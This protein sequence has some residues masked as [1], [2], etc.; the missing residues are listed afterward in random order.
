MNRIGATALAVM[1]GALISADAGRAA[2]V[3]GPSLFWKISAFGNPRALT[4]GMEEMARRVAEDT[5]G[6]FQI[7]IFYGEQLSGARENLDGLKLNAF[8]GAAICEFYHPGK[9]PA[10]TVFSLPFLPLGDPEVN[11][12]VRSRLFEH[13]AIVA[14]M[15]QWNAIPYVSGLLP[16]F[17]ILG[18]GK[19]PLRLEDWK[20]LRVRAGGGLGDAMERIGAVKMTLPAGETLTAFERG[21]LDAAAFP[22]TYAH[23][24]YRIH[25]VAEWFTTNL[26]PGSA[27]CGWVLNKQA[28]EALPPQYRDLLMGY[29][30]LVMDVQLQRYREADERNLAM[31][32]ERMTPITYTDAEIARFRELGGKPVW[33]AWIAENQ[34]RFDARG[35]FEAVWA[36]A[37]EAR[38][39]R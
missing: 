38:A 35:L 18:R 3:E 21:A 22:F 8:E 12:H 28:F 4:A 24:A 27:E 29:R 1:L 16:Q 17:E 6:R 39:G 31:F 25:E 15:A 9:N 32:R 20:G 37:E 7:K 2:G 30:D 14:D 34:D 11:R 19:P 10:W 23:V 33:E 13:P 5:D 36:L 26:A